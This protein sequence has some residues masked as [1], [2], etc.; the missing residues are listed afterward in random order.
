M[1]PHTETA[2]NALQEV[3]LLIGLLRRTLLDNLDD[4]LTV[5]HALDRAVLALQSASEKELS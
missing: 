3:T 1:T 5:K 2:V 4:L